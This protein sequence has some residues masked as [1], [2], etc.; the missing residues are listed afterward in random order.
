VQTIRLETAGTGP[1][2]AGSSLSVHVILEARRGP[3]LYSVPHALVHLAILHAPGKGAAVTPSV[4]KSSD[5]GD[6]VVSLRTGDAAGHNVMEAT[7]GQASA[8]LEVTTIAAA[9]PQQVA[10]SAPGGGV[11]PTGAGRALLIAGLAGVSLAGFAAVLLSSG[12]F[13]WG[14]RRVWGRRST[15]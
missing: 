11:G 1:L 9:K 15:S 8:Q 6:L 3:D 12:R 5:T 2:V 13:P 7:S 4:A 10:S 14:R